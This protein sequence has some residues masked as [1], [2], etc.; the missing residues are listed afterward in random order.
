MGEKGHFEEIFFI[1]NFLEFKSVI[2][3]NLMTF[4]EFEKLFNYQNKVHY[5]IFQSFITFFV[6]V[7]LKK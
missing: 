6:F 3:Q 1:I 7:P 4:G 2:Q 5:H